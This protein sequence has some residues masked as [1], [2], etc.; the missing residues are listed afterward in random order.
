MLLMMMKSLT[1]MPQ[2]H[3]QKMQQQQQQLVSLSPALHCYDQKT[4]SILVPQLLCSA[5]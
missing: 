1:I 4:C 2:H 3:H 5:R